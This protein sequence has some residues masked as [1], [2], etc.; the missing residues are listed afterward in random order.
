MRRTACLS[1]CLLLSM[2]CAWAQKTETQN[3]RYRWTDAAG[4]LHLGDAIPPEDVK[5]GYDLINQYGRVVR[6][7]DGVKTPE[8]LEE[9]KARAKAARQAAEQ[10]RMDQ[11]LLASYAREEDLVAAHNEH[12]TILKQR[13]DATEINMKSQL[14]GLANALDQAAAFKQRGERVPPYV[15]AEIEKQR[16]VVREQR[17]W[18]AQ[19]NQELAK[20]TRDAEAELARYRQL[21][22]GTGAA[23]ASSTP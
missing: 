9:E 12:I 2:P 22:G 3:L 5:G 11:Q 4:Q 8:Q 15:E 10:A 17:E 19:A 18:L 14:D 13:I 16:K 21:R 6:H 20:T 1:L 7:V 23:T